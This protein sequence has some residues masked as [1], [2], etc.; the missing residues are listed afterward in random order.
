MIFVFVVLQRA[1]ATD[2]SKHHERQQVET[3]WFEFC[4][5]PGESVSRDK[6][7]SGWLW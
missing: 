1:L 2:M 4:D 6:D 5:V 3:E 7:A